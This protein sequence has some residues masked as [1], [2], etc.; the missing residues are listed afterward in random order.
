MAKKDIQGNLVK[1]TPVR[2]INLDKVTRCMK[3]GKTKPCSP[4]QTHEM[5]GQVQPKNRFLRL[6]DVLFP[7]FKQI[8]QHIMEVSNNALKNHAPCYGRHSNSFAADGSE[9][10][11]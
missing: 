3:I 11:G 5:N 6:M 8:S 4:G 10:N 1:V 2:P 7:D 9:A